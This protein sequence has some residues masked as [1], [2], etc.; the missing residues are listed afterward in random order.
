MS[1][2]ASSGSPILDRLRDQNLT[3]LVER[4]GRLVFASDRRGMRT[5]YYAVVEHLDLFEGADVADRVVGLASAY[6][7]LHARAARVFATVMSHDARR[8][9]RESGIPHEA[10]TFVKQVVDAP[11]DAAVPMEAIAREAGSPGRFV[12]ELRARLA[13]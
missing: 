10:Q 9:L 7:L 3:L 12:E 6:V 4:G 8:A 5:L 11:H 1:S 2:P 13:P